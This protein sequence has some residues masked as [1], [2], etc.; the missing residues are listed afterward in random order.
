MR[1]FLDSFLYE[2]IWDIQVKRWPEICSG[3]WSHYGFL[4]V[5]FSSSLFAGWP[6]DDINA[7]NVFFFIVLY[8]PSFSWQCQEISYDGK[9]PPLDANHWCIVSVIFRKTRQ[10]TR[11]SKRDIFP[12][13]PTEVLCLCVSCGDLRRCRDPVCFGIQ[14]TP[15]YRILQCRDTAFMKYLSCFHSSQSCLHV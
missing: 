12:L 10:Y 2:A 14:M 11:N 9:L 13:L 5:V 1:S 8:S 15:N 4:C 3:K 7:V 6:H